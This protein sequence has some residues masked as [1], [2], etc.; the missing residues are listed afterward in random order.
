MKNEQFNYV[1][2]A[3]KHLT[4]DECIKIIENELGKFILQNRTFDSHHLNALKIRLVKL[5][6][7]I[8]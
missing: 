7:E 5:I 6:K 8:K 2:S 4:K 3:E 1:L